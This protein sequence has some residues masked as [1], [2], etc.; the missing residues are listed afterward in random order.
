MTDSG[1]LQEQSTALG[2]PCVTLR[3]NTERPATI[4]MGTNIL[5]G[6]RKD[7]LSMPTRRPSIGKEKASRYLPNGMAGLRREYGRCS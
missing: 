5:A 4:E 2:V 1:G 3:E 7:L 6:T